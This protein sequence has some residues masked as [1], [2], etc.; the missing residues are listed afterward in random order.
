MNAPMVCTAA[1]NRWMTLRTFK[2][3]FYLQGLAIDLPCES[4]DAF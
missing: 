1:L 2:E 4:F 3:I